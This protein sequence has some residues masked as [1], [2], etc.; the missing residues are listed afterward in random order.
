MTR[1]QASSMAGSITR[2]EGSR[3]NNIH[4]TQHYICPTPGL[5]V[6]EAGTCLP[7]KK[8]RKQE[9]KIDT[10]RKDARTDTWPVWRDD[11]QFTVFVRSGKSRAT[12]LCLFSVAWCRYLGQ[13]YSTTGGDCNYEAAK[14]SIIVFANFPQNG[15]FIRHISPRFVFLASN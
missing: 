12:N 3:C 6:R 8:D 7:A 11:W 9:K 1:L 13:L 15:C 10:A 2:K 14:V 4:F 5:L